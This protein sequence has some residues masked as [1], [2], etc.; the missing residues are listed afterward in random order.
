MTIKVTRYVMKTN[1]SAFRF[2]RVRL[3]IIL[4]STVKTKCMRDCDKEFEMKTMAQ[5]KLPPE[6]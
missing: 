5:T 2:H 3:K 4:R 1:S 6:P